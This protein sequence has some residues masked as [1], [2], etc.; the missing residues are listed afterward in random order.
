MEHSSANILTHCVDGGGGRD[1]GRGT[2]L[3]KKK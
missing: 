1:K 2:G 3:S